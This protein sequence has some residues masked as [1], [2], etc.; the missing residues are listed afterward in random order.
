MH[1][2]SLPSSPVIYEIPN[3]NSE[4]PAAARW[5]IVV[6]DGDRVRI[7][8][9]NHDLLGRGILP[10]IDIEKLEEPVII[11]TAHPSC[12]EVAV[13]A[14]VIIEIVENLGQKPAA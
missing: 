14:A 12:G 11:E 4:R 2:D 9:P 1:K 8:S 6:D 10:E 7:L 3:Q 13:P 5:G